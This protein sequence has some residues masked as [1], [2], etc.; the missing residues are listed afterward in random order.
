MYYV[1]FF[2]DKFA[3]S[4]ENVEKNLETHQFLYFT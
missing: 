2:N 4:G 1:Y 3:I